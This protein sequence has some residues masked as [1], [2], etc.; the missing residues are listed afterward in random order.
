MERL[1]NDRMTP[2]RPSGGLPW[3]SLLWPG[4]LAIT[5]TV[6]LAMAIGAMFA[7]HASGAVGV[8]AVVVAAVATWVGALTALGMTASAGSGPNSV[9]WLLGGA[10]IRFGLPLVVGVFLDS[11]G[12]ALADAG[13]FGW[14]VAFF[15]VVLA[16]ETPFAIRIVKRASPKRGGA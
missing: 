5:V 1:P 15:L 6:V 4:A 2:E 13:V 9:S 8:L 7:F 14:I 12:G 10:S 11:R 3:F 16:V